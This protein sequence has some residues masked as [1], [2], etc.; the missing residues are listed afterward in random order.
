MLAH[1]ILDNSQ[2]EPEAKEI[3][4]RAFDGAWTTVAENF[5]EGLQTESAQMKLARAVLLVARHHIGDG[6]ILQAASLRI[7]GDY[8][9]ML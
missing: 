5:A 9:T 3:I 1:Q 4:H 2:F 8:F 6:A 7:L